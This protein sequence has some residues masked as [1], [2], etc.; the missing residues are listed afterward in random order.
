MRIIDIALVFALT[1][2]LAFANGENNLHQQN[3][4]PKGFQIAQCGWA[5][6]CWGFH[7]G[8]TYIDTKARDI[9][10]CHQSL[11]KCSGNNNITANFSTNAALQDCSKNIVQC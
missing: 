2:T 7:N 5:T 10:W 8:M 3:L 11:V 1:T 4:Q 6:N 9:Q